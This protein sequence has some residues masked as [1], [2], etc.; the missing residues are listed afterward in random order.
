M[1]NILKFNLVLGLM[2]LSNILLYAQEVNEKVFFTTGL[3]IGEVSSN[4][5][6]ILTRLCADEKPV[7]LKHKR[8]KAPLCKPIDFDESM[9]VEKM[10]GFVKGAFGEVRIELNSKN[11]NILLDWEAV[12]AYQDYTLK[13]RFEGLKSNTKYNLVIKGRKNEKSPISEIQ[14]GF[15]TKPKSNEI[16]PIIFTTTTCQMYWTYDDTERG[17]KVYDAMAK[18]NPNFHVQTG[19]YVYYDKPGPYAKTIELARHKWHAIN[20]FPSLV[21]FYAN[22][23]LY[24][25]KD[26]HDLL[27]DDTSPGS[28]PYGEITYKDGLKIWYEQAPIIEKPYRTFQWG[29]D[30]QIWLVD[31]R[32]YRSDNWEEDNKDKTILGAEQKEWLQKTIKKSNASFKVLITPTPIVGP[33]RIKGKNDNH[34]NKSFQTEGEWFRSYLAKN[35]VIVTNGDRHW[36]YVSKDPKTGLMEFSQGATSNEHAGGWKKNEL[37]PEHKFLRIKGGFLAVKVDR[38][39]NKPIARFQHYDVDGNMVHEEVIF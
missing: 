37:R 22:V 33:D 6:I 24:L 25:E 19:D 21:D 8:T 10:E 34:A 28:T 16:E 29:K 18:L 23:P 17:L 39:N 38:E 32:E 14:G 13:H 31:V 15:K 26:D 11:H 4:S 27:K 36:Q 5:A 12:S 1:K 3:K 35:D 7:P 9:P 2:F 20:S 30:L